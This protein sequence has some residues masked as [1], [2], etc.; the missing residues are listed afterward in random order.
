M[1]T[2]GEIAEILRMSPEWVRAQCDSGEMPAHKLGREWRIDADEF[3]AWRERQR[4]VPHPSYRTERMT[5]SRNS[6]DRG[7]LRDLL[8]ERATRE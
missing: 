6:N 5:P 1:L 7:S 4:H 3:D 2:T 8:M